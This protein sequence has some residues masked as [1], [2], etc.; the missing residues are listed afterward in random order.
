MSYRS[1]HLGLELDPL[2][3]GELFCIVPPDQVLARRELISSSEIAR[4]PLVGIDPADLCGGILA[5]TLQRQCLTD[6]IPIE[7]RFGTTVCALVKS[8]PGGSR[9]STGS[10]SCTRV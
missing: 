4:H 5:E 3:T 7:A 2:A 10:R 1:E 6:E 9:S 8:G